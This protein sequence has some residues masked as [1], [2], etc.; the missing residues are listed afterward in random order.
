M[1]IYDSVVDTIGRTPLIHLGRL[2]SKVEARVLGK[3]ESRNPCGSIKDRI[4]VA[5]IRDAERRG[6][7]QPGAVIVEA[8]SGNTGI[9]LAF[10]AAALGYRLV[11][12][13]PENMSRERIAL[14]RM[15]G[16]EVVLTR[17]G[18]MRDAVNKAKELLRAT[19]GAVSLEQFR[20]PANPEAHA[21]T[22]AREILEDTEGRIGAFVAGVGTGGTISGVGRVLKDKC[23]EARIIAV[24]P[25]DSA[26]LSGKP[27]APHYIQ[28]IGAGFVPENL[29]LDIVD[30][31]IPVSERAALTHARRLAREEGILAGISS[32]AAV[33]AA[34]RVAKRNSMKGQDVVVILPDTGERYLS[35]ALVEDLGGA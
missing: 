17:G 27:P 33:A 11:I 32:G 29:D 5:M 15:F 20:N 1:P 35:T 24:E 21:R 7:L 16:A 6:V 4:G 23:P 12:T 31:I 13:M 34:L 30:E 10:A 14:L 18:M 8:T 22:T 19:P 2:G 25:S 26:V 28:G 9:A 3:M